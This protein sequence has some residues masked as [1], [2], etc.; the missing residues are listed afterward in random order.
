MLLAKALSEPTAAAAEVA[1][2]VSFMTAMPRL[3]VISLL[4]H[5]LV[6][7]ES[8]ER[9]ANLMMKDT[10]HWPQ[11]GHVAELF[12]LWSA[13]ANAGLEWTRSLIA[14]LAAGEYEMAGD[15][16]GAFG[17]PPA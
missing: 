1:A 17:D 9:S 3:R 6:P 10:A 12:R 15:S 8:E 4:E 13:Q 11:A 5:R 14:R 16:G 7:L 2:G